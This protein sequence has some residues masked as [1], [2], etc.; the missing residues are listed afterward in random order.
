MNPTKDETMALLAEWYDAWSEELFR[1]AFYRLSSRED[2]EDVVQE[3]FLR[4]A[5]SDLSRLKEPRAYLYRAIHNG[6][7]DFLR[8]RR[9]TFEIDQRLAKQPEVEEREALEEAAQINQLLNKLPEEQ[10]EVVRLHL[11]ANLKF[12][13]ISELLQLPA[14]TLKSRFA[15]GIERLKKMWNN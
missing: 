1:F 5:K 7:N 11:H 10:S 2:A 4:V 15:A 14:S 8:H 3:A 6:C 9:P 12:T 13:E